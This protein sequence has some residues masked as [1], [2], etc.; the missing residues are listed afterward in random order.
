MFGKYGLLLTRVI[1]ILSVVFFSPNCLLAQNMKN[2]KNQDIHKELKMPDFRYPETVQKN[3][4]SLLQKAIKAKDQNT[5]VAALIQISLAQTSVTERSVDEVIARIDSV[6]NLG[7]LSA[8]YKA[9]LW[10]IEAEIYSGRN[11][12]FDFDGNAQQKAVEAAGKALDPEGNGDKSSL[13][14]PLSAYGRLFVPGNDLGKRAMPLLYDF[15]T[16]NVVPYIKD[17]AKVKQLNEDWKKLHEADSDVM[18]QMFIECHDLLAINNGRHRRVFGNQNSSLSRTYYNIYKEYEESALLLRQFGRQDSY[19]EVCE[20]LQRFPNSVFAPEIANIRAN[21]EAM[22]VNVQTRKV[23]QSSDSIKVQASLSNVSECTLTLYRVP[24]DVMKSKKAIPVSRLQKLESRKVSASGTVPFTQD[25]I[26]AVFS[27]QPYGRYMVLASFETPKGQKS[28]TE[29]EQYELNHEVFLVS[30]LRTFA[31]NNKIF[32]VNSHNG[33]CEKDVKVMLSK[34]WDG[35]VTDHVLF[36]NS[37][38]FVAAPEER[39]YNYSLEKGSDR[40]LPSSSLYYYRPGVQDREQCSVFSDLRIYRPGETARISVVAYQIGEKS[41]KP[42]ANA[43]LS[44]RFIDASGNDIEEKKIVTDDFGQALCEFVVPTDRMN[45][46]FNV[47]VVA[48][49][50]ERRTLGYHSIEVSEYKTPTFY[51]DL[52]ETQTTQPADGQAV[53]KGR[54]MTYSGL[55]VVNADVKCTLSPS[56]W[57]C[58]MGDS[59]LGEQE[60]SVTTD[61][62]GRFEYVCPKDWTCDDDEG[63]ENNYL[64][65]FYTFGLSVHATN[66][67]GETQIGETRFW[68]G[69]NRYIQLSGDATY[70]LESGKKLRLGVSFHSTDPAE[71]SALCTYVLFDQDRQKI[72][73][74]EFQSDSPLVDWSSIPSGK[75]RIEAGIKG[76]P[77]EKVSKSDV[78]LYRESD[79]MPPFQTPL[80]MPKSS[81]TVSADKVRMLIGNHQESYIYFE[82]ASRTHIE[83]SGWLQYQPGMHWLELTMPSGKDEF[84]DVKFFAMSEGQ[85]FSESLHFNS[86][87][88]DQIKLSAVSFRDKSVPGSSEHWTFSLR[89]ADGK[90]VVGRMMLDLYNQALENL[91]SNNWYMTVPYASRSVLNFSVPDFYRQT[92][93]WML[94][95]SE[96]DGRVQSLWIDLARLQFYDMQFFRKPRYLMRE[97]TYGAQS[98]RVYDAVY[99]VCEDSEIAEEEM[100]T[101]E[102][103]VGCSASS[104]KNAGAPAPEAATG[105]VAGTDEGAADM[106]FDNVSLRTGEVKVALWLPQL[107]TDAEGNFTIDFE[108]PNFNTT[109]CLQAL[110]YNQTMASDIFREKVL[111]QRPIMVQPSLPRFLRAGDKTQL[112]A[113]VMNASDEEQTVRVVVELFDPR[114]SE[115]FK[116]ERQEILLPSQG[117]KAVFIEYEAPAE[118]PFVGFRIK[119]LD[120]N[121]NGD[122][123]QQMFPIL[124][125]IS[126]VIETQPFYKH[127]GENEIV[128]EVETPETLKPS[129]TLNTASRLVLEYCDNPTWYC[130]TALPTIANTDAITSPGLAHSLFAIALASR[131]ADQ[132]PAV[133]DAIKE[134]KT[135]AEAGEDSPLTSMLRKNSDLKIADLLASP[136]MPEAER[137]ELR[138]AALDQLFV[139]ARSQAEYDKLLDKLEALR[140]PDGGFAWIDDSKCPYSDHKSSYWATG[141]VLELVGELWHL[142]C[143]RSET[144]LAE[145]MR[146]AVL[147]FDRETIRREDEMLKAYQNSKSWFKKKPEPS[148][149]Q[150]CH[151]AYIRTLF[152]GIA[153]EPALRSRIDKLTAKTLES[154]AK[155]WGNQSIP[156]KAF[157]A[158]VLHRNNRSAD[159]RKITESLRQFAVND[160]HRGMYWENIDRYSWS[161]PVACTA[162]VL[163]AFAEVDPRTEEIDQ[164][165]QWMLLEKQTSDW[166]GSSMAA[167]A[168]YALLST[169]T[170]WLHAQ[171][172][173]SADAK[174]SAPS[175]LLDG[176][177][178][179]LPRT[180]SRLG[181]FRMELPA[182]VRN[183]AISRSGNNPAW[184]SLYHQFQ[185][186][187]QQVKAQSVPEV[188]IE[189][190][191][192]VD[193]NLAKV[194]LTVICDKALEY[195]TICDERP[196]CLEPSDQHSGY[197]WG[198]GEFYYLET[199]DSETRIFCNRLSEGRHVF[200]Y[201]CSITNSGEFTSGIA[202][203]QSQYAPQFTAHSAGERKS[204]K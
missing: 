194:I 82:A 41:R 169:G 187:M 160:Q 42:L 26:E 75:Y 45:G 3:A 88:V 168:V 35:E 68:M 22:R 186:P 175:L 176:K 29:L 69:S 24:D 151:Y 72:A 77:I 44:V 38:G 84:L 59:D 124:T 104:M 115:V 33:R 200:T 132:N 146:Q 8:D 201:E 198:S 28:K 94:D 140:R 139:Q 86:L 105:S 31:V 95:Y 165:R 61:A 103:A 15:L 10:L 167:D 83:A 196:A 141:E 30:D 13:M 36:T 197:H 87:N 177:L 53:I 190:K 170:D 58:W 100:A 19:A 99:A 85:E 184:G 116:T 171:G 172:A 109:W 179:Q 191:I 37:Q 5:V 16:E 183:I 92:T 78:A 129:G 18:P 163:N 119:A 121:G 50:S 182:D 123:E 39:Y 118:A 152:Q 149:M 113:N 54:V 90:P 195:V 106:D 203:I 202:T 127:P 155:E 34:S 114:T 60:F 48:D 47:R 80:F 180:D 111:A 147:Y 126:P 52:S 164:I 70:R 73:E 185:A 66:E 136:W 108:V 166:G 130:V 150:F 159:A 23:F 162:V 178:V 27:P 96:F 192:E 193:G 9:I 98:N 49:A 20:Y 97:R 91:R 51:V 81:Q 117:T 144:R 199:K 135:M 101:E 2:N 102:M 133:L 4:E 145:M 46:M 63:V 67:A 134:L 156:E 137:Q 112:A 1:V 56:L 107:N 93:S 55:P 148:Y 62:E 76:E 17:E 25:N 174:T 158:I 32:A 161:L 120:A 65:S 110:A 143:L 181:Y 173:S 131:F 71:T 12:R 74:G 189:K 154:I 21:Y 142:G 188:K 157:S 11:E 122:G 64:R 43:K 125:N 89:D 57:W 153:C 14:K 79:A 128:L 7:V 40:L 204:Y 6:I 138:M